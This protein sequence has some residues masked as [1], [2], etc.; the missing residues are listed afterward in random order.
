MITTDVRQDRVEIRAY[1][2]L[3]LSDCQ[4]FEQLSDYRVRFSGPIDLLLD[5]RSM[6]GYSL[7]VALEEWRY[8]RAHNTSIRRI[9]LVTDDQ[10]VTWGAWF[11]QF[12]TQAD[13]RV[14]D[15]E[16]GARRWLEGED[17]LA[18][19]GSDLLH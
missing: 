13:I 19:P 6:T 12:F 3:T 1:G 15:S 5:L 18:D 16:H 8:L 10:F 4:T 11:S 14:F 7:D 2:R 9:A 17:L